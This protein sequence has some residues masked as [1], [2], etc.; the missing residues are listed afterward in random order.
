[1]AV[2]RRV[3]M[4]I[5]IAALTAALA[6][7][8]L[9]RGQGRLI[10][11][12]SQAVPPVAAALPGARDVAFATADGLRLGGWFLPAAGGGRGP[13]VLVLNGN[14]GNRAH[15]APLAAALAREGFGVLLFDYRGYGGNPGTPTEAGLLADARA[16]R[17]HLA[18]RGDVD[19]A[20]LVYL[21]ESLGA[22]VAVALAAEA[23]P[24]A[25]VLRSPFTSLTDVGR[26]HYPLL[27]VGPLLRDRYP[28]LDR[29]GRVA[30]PV[31]VVAGERDRLVPV[32]QSRRL[33]AAAAEPKRFM[34]IAGA[35]H[36]DHALLAGDQFIGEVLRFLGEAAAP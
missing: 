20:R 19:P 34:L 5:A 7:A 6:L 3:L 13:A 11:F 16:A 9:W 25:L 22:A 28:N 4:G 12:P 24:R 17:A 30:A 15:R 1:M 8:L 27:P 14:G 26:L 2:R 36:N 10:Y 29:I 21:G 33:H 32:E 18:A 35:D 31:L 23:P